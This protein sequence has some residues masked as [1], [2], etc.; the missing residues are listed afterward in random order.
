MPSS[1]RE[2]LGPRVRVADASRVLYGS[3]V[4]YLLRAEPSFVKT[5]SAGLALARRH[6]PLGVAKDVVER[7][8]DKEEV[9]VEVPKVEDPAVFEHELEELGIQAIRRETEPK[10]AKALAVNSQR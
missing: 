7:L 1:L 8:L 2:R 10:S 3:P 4:R 6:L 9:T 5:V